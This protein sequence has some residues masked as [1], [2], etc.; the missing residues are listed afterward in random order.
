MHLTAAQWIEF[1]FGVSQVIQK[2]DTR[3][4]LTLGSKYRL[5]WHPSLTL[6]PLIA[7]LDGGLQFHTAHSLNS[8]WAPACVD[9][10]AQ[11]Q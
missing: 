6:S 9:T 3:L 10:N 8:L 2:V 7:S 1:I 5:G 11:L 4:H